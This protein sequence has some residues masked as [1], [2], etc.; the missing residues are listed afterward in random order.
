M[1]LSFLYEPSR[2]LP[3]CSLVLLPLKVLMMW[4]HF[5]NT[6]TRYLARLGVSYA[7]QSKLSKLRACTTSGRNGSYVACGA[8]VQNARLAGQVFQ[9]RIRSLLK[10]DL[11][12]WMGEMAGCGL[13][14]WGSIAIMICDRPNWPLAGSPTPWSSPQASVVIKISLA[15]ILLINQESCL[16]M[17]TLLQWA[18]KYMLCAQACWKLTPCL[19]SSRYVHSN[20][21][22]FQFIHSFI[23]SCPGVHVIEQVFIFVLLL[24]HCRR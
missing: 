8:E 14:A 16:T 6:I 15:L 2:R 3:P 5:Q 21:S 18:A 22:L 19:N 1:S 13:G 10:W 24:C 12:L 23:H 20:V 17:T 9:S 11:C 4:L 7:A